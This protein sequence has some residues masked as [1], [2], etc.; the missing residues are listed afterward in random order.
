MK[1]KVFIL[2]FL[3]MIFSCKTTEKTTVVNYKIKLSDYVKMYSE[4]GAISEDPLIIVNS[5]PYKLYSELNEDDVDLMEQLVRNY[6]Y[7]RQK[8]NYFIDKLGAKAYGGII[9]IKNVII[10]YCG[11]SC[12][13]D[14]I[15]DGKVST[16]DEYEK[17]LIEKKYNYYNSIYRLK[18]IDNEYVSI[19]IL[20][21]K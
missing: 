21:T 20:E 2:L 17:L 14:Y 6:S 18:L 9:H 11:T 1:I 16:F 10:L 5:K 19:S 8:N 15:I 13:R 7:F 12:K 3:A 4:K